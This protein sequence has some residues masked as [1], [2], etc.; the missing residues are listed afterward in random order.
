MRGPAPVGVGRVV[1]SALAPPAAAAAALPAALAPPHRHH[2]SGTR[3][4]GRARGGARP[5][6][7]AAGRVVA[8]AGTQHAGRRESGHPSRCRRHHREKPA[9]GQREH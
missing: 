3:G 4:S 5:A 7:P 9:R 6:K 1:P 8:A 2:Q